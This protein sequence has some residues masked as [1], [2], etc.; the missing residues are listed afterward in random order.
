MNRLSI[1]QEIKKKN[2]TEPNRTERLNKEEKI[3]VILPW[4]SCNGAPIHQQNIVVICSQECYH[5]PRECSGNQFGVMF[6]QICQMPTKKE[7]CE[8][9]LLIL[10]LT[11]SFIISFGFRL[12]ILHAQPFIW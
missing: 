10:G 7:V 3:L 6:E 8:H 12:A 9:T 4:Q 2:R 11:F 1:S 5:I